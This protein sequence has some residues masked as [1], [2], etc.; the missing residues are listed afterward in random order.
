VSTPSVYELTVIAL[1]AEPGEGTTFSPFAD[2]NAGRLAWVTAVATG[3]NRYASLLRT[4]GD[5]RTRMRCEWS[6]KGGF[7]DSTE[8]HRQELAALCAE[9][10]ASAPEGYRAELEGSW[11]T[12][13]GRPVPQ[14]ILA[15]LSTAERVRAHWSGY[16]AGLA[17]WAAFVLAAVDRRHGRAPTP[18]TAVSALHAS[19]S[20]GTGPDQGS[21]SGAPPPGSGWAAGGGRRAGRAG[22][23]CRSI[24]TGEGEVAS[25]RSIFLGA[26]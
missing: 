5:H 9:L 15:D 12:F 4:S 11:V 14:A 21:G 8:A 18:P 22:G 19:A 7:Q 2:E 16:L 25:P 10:T 26:A 23:S 24:D 17:L 6:K 13:T 3:A 1:D 20:R